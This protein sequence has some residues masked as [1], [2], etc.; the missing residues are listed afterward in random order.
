MFQHSRLCWIGIDGNA[1]AEARHAD[2]TLDALTFNHALLWAAQARSMTRAVAAAQVR[3][4][5]PVSGASALN[6]GLI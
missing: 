5:T 1:A 6:S 4:A 3:R 2:A